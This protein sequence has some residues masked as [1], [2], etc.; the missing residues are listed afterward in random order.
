MAFSAILKSGIWLGAVFMLLVMDAEGRAVPREQEFRA[1]D[2]LY[3][4]ELEPV[5]NEGMLVG[6]S[7]AEDEASGLGIQIITSAP[8]NET[9]E[10]DNL[11]P[12]PIGTS[13][14]SETPPPKLAQKVTDDIFDNVENNV[15]PTTPGTDDDIIDIIDVEPT[16]PSLTNEPP[17]R[18][19][20][21]SASEEEPTTESPSEKAT[22][23]KSSEKAT[24][25][26]PSK[27]EITESPSKE[28]TTQ[29][30]SEEATTAS[31]SE[32]KNNR[33]AF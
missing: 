26:S 21:Q 2:D 16:T 30:P 6:Y 7:P 5:Y 28:P 14:E 12:T 3:P 9:N 32:K 31:P 25:Q 23:E 8:V 17:L 20:K 18:T 33:V 27:E 15:D 22:T 1:E 29:T 11:L 4:V 10:K 24:T 13:V 19:T